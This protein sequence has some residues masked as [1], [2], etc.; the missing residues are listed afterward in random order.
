MD[1]RYSIATF[2]SH[3]NQTYLLLDAN[4]VS[5]MRDTKSQDVLICSACAGERLPVFWSCPSGAVHEPPDKI[6]DSEQ[7]HE[8]GI[9]G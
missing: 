5:T 7:R 3:K 2:R 8:I 4:T 1:E 9:M 6:R